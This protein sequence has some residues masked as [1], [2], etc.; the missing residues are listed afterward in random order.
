M[1]E[2]GPATLYAADVFGG[3]ATGGANDDIARGLAWLV[4]KDVRVINVSI[5]GQKN[6][7][8]WTPVS[9]AS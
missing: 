8:S 9:L 3:S 6:A 4:D 5:T 2:G 1:A 7:L